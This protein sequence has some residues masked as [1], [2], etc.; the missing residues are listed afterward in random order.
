MCINHEC[1]WLDEAVKDMQQGYKGGSHYLEWEVHSSNTYAALLVGGNVHNL[2]QWIVLVEHMVYTL[3]QYSDPVLTAVMQD[4]QEKAK[5]LL[6]NEV[7]LQNLQSICAGW[8]GAPF[9][10][11][12]LPT[13]MCKSLKQLTQSYERT[14]IYQLLKDIITPANKEDDEPIVVPVCEFNLNNWES[15]VEQFQ[16][17][18]LESLWQVLGWDIPPNFSESKTS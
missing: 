18:H 8:P 14:S 2:Q 3:K 11:P 13:P 10:F 9:I 12:E 7:S 1:K 16:D 15:G 17:W 4:L 6:W 5:Q